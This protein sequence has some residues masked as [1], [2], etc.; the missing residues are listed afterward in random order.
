[1]HLKCLL[2]IEQFFKETIE[3]TQQRIK[4]LNYR[5]KGRRNIPLN[6]YI[7]TLKQ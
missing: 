1:M 4:N 6:S 3:V 7:S 2:E 5:E